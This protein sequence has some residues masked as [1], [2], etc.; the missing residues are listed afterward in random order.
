MMK[1]FAKTGIAQLWV[2]LLLTGLSMVMVSAVA[3]AVKIGDEYGG[4][5]IAWLDASGQHGL[6]AAKADCPGPYFI[7]A[8]CEKSLSGL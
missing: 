6:I 2:V 7:M 4:G 3:S 8:R 1:L 5:K